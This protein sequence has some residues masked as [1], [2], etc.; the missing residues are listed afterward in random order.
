[1]LFL[2]QI[3][4]LLAERT[5]ASNS[6]FGGL[7]VIFSGDFF[8]LPPVNKANTTFSTDNNNNIDLII[9]NSQPQQ[10][11]PPYVNYELSVFTQTNRHVNSKVGLGKA[12]FCFQT[13]AWKETIDTNVI[14]TKAFRQSNNEFASCLESIRWGRS[15]MVPSFQKSVGRKLCCDDGILPTRIYT[16]RHDV[17]LIN[18]RELAALT[19]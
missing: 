16:H 15:D 3:L 13:D 8:Q 18:Q 6:P 9:L 19:G 17:D 7:Q 14:L 10:P 1:M 11:P 4:K 5:R 12:K 2:N